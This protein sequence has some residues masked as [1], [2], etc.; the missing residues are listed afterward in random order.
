MYYIIYETLIFEY[1]LQIDKIQKVLRRGR[2]TE[3]CDA[4]Q[5]GV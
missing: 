1:Y 2:Y 5:Q 3:E 4:T